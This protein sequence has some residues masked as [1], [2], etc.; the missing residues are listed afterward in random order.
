MASGTSE[1][2]AEQRS[3]VVA[4]IAVALLGA[5]I[6][7]DFVIGSFWS[8][9]AMV[10][11]LAASLLVVVISVAVINELLERRERKRWQLLAQAVLFA[12][13]SSARLT[14]TTM[15]ELLRLT[16]VHSGAVASLLEGAK[17]A[18]DQPRV[19]AAARELLADPERRPKLQL[20]VERL[21]DRGGDVIAKWATML[22]GA[23][24]YASL[25]ERHVEL[26][27]RLEWLASVL[28]HREPAQEGGRG[29]RLT[30]ASVA[31]ERADEFDD[32]WIHDMIVVITT[33][34]TRLDYDSRTLAF[35]LFSEQW[36][37]QR[38]Q[39]LLET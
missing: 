34:S 13:T 9:H 20:A 33:M 11:S 15:V 32:D 27:A 6:A 19:S 2:R 23:A 22:V 4:A 37:I 29:R 10:T 7:S 12:L 14:W 26:Q 30:T 3:V 28:A 36:W 25:L 38:T 16:E 31:T 35:S 39:T 1:W 17:V 18:V 24:P 5:A 21:A 8:R